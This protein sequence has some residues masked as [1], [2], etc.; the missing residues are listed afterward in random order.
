[1]GD[2]L[3]GLPVCNQ[4]PV[5]LGPGA[6]LL[7][8]FA[9]PQARTLLTDLLAVA[10]AAPFRHLTTP[11]GAEMSVAM[12]N[13]GPLGWISDRRGYRYEPADPATG[14]AWPALPA[15]LLDVARRAAI[16][17][18]YAGFSPDACLVNRY[19]PGSKLSLHQD[20]DELDLAA[21]IVSISLGL[22]AV[23]LFG[24]LERAGRP[25]RMRLA[26]GD[27]V[28]WGGASRLVY[29][30]VAPLAEGS[31]PLTGRVR[32]NLTFRTVGQAPG[33]GAATF[34]PAGMGG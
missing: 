14:K 30:G 24:G 18:G 26:S 22:P 21:P 6:W 15:C 3:D 27:V 17:V 20:R 11:G 16:S 33:A 13:C 7:P 2:L 23:F 32:Y 29:H 31:H 1:M 19:V 25:R 9:T 8:G 5:V 34:V 10:E 12:T 4:D 28:L